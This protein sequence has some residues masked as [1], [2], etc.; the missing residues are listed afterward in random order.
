MSATRVEPELRIV[1]PLTLELAPMAP[2]GE[3]VSDGELDMRQHVFWTT[4]DNTTANGI[5]SCPP[6][7]LTLEHPW[8]ETF[9]V[10]E[11]RLTVTPA[12]G[13]PRELAAGDAIVIP[14]GAVNDWEIHETVRKLFVVHR[15][16]GLPD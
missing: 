11:G 7:K 3:D 10:L 9:V 2:T 14:R 13:E 12:G 6:V 8:D 4:P 16:E 15:S 1:D 5:W